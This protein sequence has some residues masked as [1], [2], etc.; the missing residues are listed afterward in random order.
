MSS[1]DIEGKANT[2]Y[3]CVSRK[4]VF[5]SILKEFEIIDSTNKNNNVY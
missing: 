2:E 5:E 3:R 1:S 4:R